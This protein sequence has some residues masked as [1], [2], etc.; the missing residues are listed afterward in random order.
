MSSSSA[1][2]DTFP[3]I[4][5][6]DQLTAESNLVPPVLQT[7]SPPPIS[8]QYDFEYVLYR[9]DL[10]DVKKSWSEDRAFLP[11]TTV[12]SLTFVLGILGNGF[13][14]LALLSGWRV[15]RT[16]EGQCY[17]FSESCKPYLPQQCCTLHPVEEA[18]RPNPMPYCVIHFT[19]S[20]SL[21]KHRWTYDMKRFAVT[22]DSGGWQDISGRRLLCAV[23]WVN[24]KNGKWL[25]IGLL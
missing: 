20:L 7:P 4:N 19:I 15:G 21:A 25:P 13:V 8:S 9:E 5:P 18:I 12:Y 11:A 24:G 6:I 3:L 2:N 1:T 16:N 23:L 17:L 14:I 10:T 22:S